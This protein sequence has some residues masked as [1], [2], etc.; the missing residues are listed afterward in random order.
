MPLQ[1][2][3]ELKS[4]SLTPF[5]T[6]IRHIIRTFNH[7][8]GLICFLMPSLDHNYYCY[9]L[10]TCVSLDRR[11][12]RANRHIWNKYRFVMGLQSLNGSPLEWLRSHPRVI[13]I[14]GFKKWRKSWRHNNWPCA[15]MPRYQAHSALVEKEYSI[16]NK[17]NSW[18][19]ACTDW[20][21]YHARSASRNGLW[22]ANKCS[23]WTLATCGAAMLFGPRSVQQKMWQ[24]LIILAEGYSRPQI[25]YMQYK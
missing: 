19:L 3:S 20:P 8:K 21:G 25:K 12:V 10:L 11:F 7:C 5:S 17:C 14:K 18:T 15:E 2:N 24:D 16:A 4:N 1:L 13:E 6:N 23:S 22:R 9:V